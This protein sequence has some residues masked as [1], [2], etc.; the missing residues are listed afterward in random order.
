MK[1]RKAKKRI[2]WRRER[3]RS[4]FAQRNSKGYW[5][6]EITSRFVSATTCVSIKSEC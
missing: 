2:P 1:G 3:N 6:S 4:M 5:S